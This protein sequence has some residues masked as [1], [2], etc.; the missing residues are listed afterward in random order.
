[1]TSTSPSHQVSSKLVPFTDSEWRVISY[2][3]DVVD[4]SIYD[5]SITLDITPIHIRNIIFSLLLDKC[6]CYSHYEK[7][8]NDVEHPPRDLFAAGCVYRIAHAGSVAVQAINDIPFQP[9]A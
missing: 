5:L 3:H 9:Q 2:L 1:M 4:A 8:I 7:V 6:V